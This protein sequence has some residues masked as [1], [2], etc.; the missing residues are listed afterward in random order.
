MAR[1]AAFPLL[2]LLTLAACSPEGAVTVTLLAEGETLS[3]STEALTVGELLIELGISLDE[4]DRVQPP[5]TTFVE[6]AMVLQVIRVDV[7]TET[8]EHDVPFERLTV[9]DSSIPAGETRLLEAG[10][11]G[12]EEWTYRVTLE[13]GVQIGRQLV[14]V[15]TLEEAQS[16]ILLIGAQ[17]DIRPVTI[18]G[19][20]AYIGN[21]NAWVMQTTSANPRRLTDAWDLDSRAF[22]L[23]ADGSFL[24]YT[25]A[26]TETDHD[27]PLNRLWMVDTRAIDTEPVEL[28]AE[29]LLWA[30]WAPECSGTP[31]GTSCRIAYTTGSRIEGNPEWRAENDLW[32]A[33]PRESDGALL[34]EQLV[35]EPSAG[36]AYGWWGTEYA[37]S[38]DGQSIAY[39]RADEVG[40]IELSSGSATVLASFAAYR[41]FALW[42]WVPAVSWS[43]E[44]EF[45]VTTIHGPA[46]TGE[47]PQDSPVFDVWALAADA[48]LAAEL[49]SE[50]GMWSAPQYAAESDWVAFG[51]ARSRYVS[52]TSGYDLYVMDRDGSD[53][54]HVFPPEE[55][56]GFPYPHVAWGPGGEQLIVI[57]RGN[58]YLIDVTDGEAVRLTSD[59]G[60]TAVLWQW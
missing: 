45:I 15:V 31:T 51:R 10:V 42:A 19:T 11:V 12:V 35:V 57:Y 53:Q 56:I 21:L 39:A 48:S 27:A 7:Y 30:D 25:R 46:P 55:E 2:L 18:T 47:A 38:P 6:P 9:R 1:R 14:R 60:I 40:V 52:Q 37:W 5:E 3:V 29:G 49:S 4:D 58:L 33:R 28:D 13:D 16:E 32:V 59:G 50:T 34:G 22:S 41:A 26:V 8:E 23:S 54:R 36:G 24:L 20:V 44:G 17:T 43:P